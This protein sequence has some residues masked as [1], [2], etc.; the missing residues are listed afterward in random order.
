MLNFNSVMIFSEN[1]KK[2]VDFYEQVVG[3]KPAWHEGDFNGFAIGSCML[4]IGPHDQVRGSSQNPERLMLN[5][6]TSDVAAEFERI[7]KLGAKVIADPYGY[8]ESKTQIATLAD[9]DGNYFQLV[10]PMPLVN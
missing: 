8:G 5:F 9:P 6:E 10:T 2:L 3:G 7:K 4:V 1:P